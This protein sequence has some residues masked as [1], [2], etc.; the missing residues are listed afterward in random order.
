MR[1]GWR[2]LEAGKAVYALF[3]CLFVRARSAHTPTIDLFLR[4]R[5]RSLAC[6]RAYALVS[7][8]ACEKDERESDAIAQAHL[9]T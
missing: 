3:V 5:A 9:L 2:H 4:M 8:P 6:V 1:R 7:A